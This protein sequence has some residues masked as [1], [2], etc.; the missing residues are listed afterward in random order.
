MIYAGNRS[1]SDAAKYADRKYTHSTFH[2]GKEVRWYDCWSHADEQ[3][4]AFGEELDKRKVK[5]FDSIFRNDISNF[6]E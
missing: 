6:Q 2:H 5:A 1:E 3:R 4:P